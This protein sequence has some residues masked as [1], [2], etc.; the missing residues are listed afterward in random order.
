M[1][2]AA[3]AALALLALS[4]A[5]AA[6]AVT[7]RTSL[8]EVEPQVMCVTCNVP[9]EVAVS[10]A[11][12][13]ERQFISSLIAQGDTVAQIKAKLVAQYGDTVLALPPDRGFNLVVYLIP[14]L[15]V[16]LALALVALLLPRWRR[17]HRDTPA[18]AP[19]ATPSAAEAA[20]LDAELARFDA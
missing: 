15:V 9:L 6:A 12:D 16:V 17:N 10:P 2:R 4:G 18:A 14:I 11:A 19:G 13:Q 20:R 7:P 5:S 3:L 8:A 1:R